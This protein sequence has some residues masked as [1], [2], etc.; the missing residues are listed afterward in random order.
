MSEAADHRSDEISARLHAVASSCPDPA[1]ATTAFLKAAFEA[2]YD[3]WDQRVLKHA[4]DIGEARRAG[5]SR[6]QR[7]RDEYERSLIEVDTRVTQEYTRYG[8]KIGAS[9]PS[10]AL[11]AP[12][13]AGG[14]S[15]A[16]LN[17]ALVRSQQ[18]PTM[19]PGRAGIWELQTL[20]ALA[21][22][23]IGLGL[24]AALGGITRSADGGFTVKYALFMI[25]PLLAAP[26][27]YLW[28]QRRAARALYLHLCRLAVALKA[29]IEVE[30]EHGRE[31]RRRESDE[32][33]EIVQRA[34][35]A[36]RARALEG[37][38][39]LRSA[40][41]DYYAGRAYESHGSI[42]AVDLG[43][44]QP[45]A[46]SASAIRAGMFAVKADQQS[47]LMGEADAASM[48]GGA[49][50]P[51]NSEHRLAIAI[52]GG[53]FARFCRR[54][55]EFTNFG[56]EREDERK[57]VGETRAGL[58]EEI[59]SDLRSLVTERPD[60]G[61]A[62]EVDE[63]SQGREK[64]Q[65]V[66]DS[67]SEPI[68]KAITLQALLI[69]ADPATGRHQPELLL[70]TLGR[71]VSIKCADAAEAEA[72]KARLLQ[73]LQRDGKHADFVR[74]AVSSATDGVVPE[75]IIDSTGVLPAYDLDEVRFARA[76]L[77][78]EK[79]AL[80][81]G[82]LSLRP[83]RPLL[84]S[85]ANE[86][87]MA[88]AREATTAIVWRLL[89]NIPPGRVHFTFI[90]PVGL[91]QNVAGFLELADSDPRLVSTRAW[92]DMRHIEGRLADL[93]THMETV[94]QKYL[95]TIHK[96]IDAYNAE[97][98]AIEAYRVLVVFDFPEQFSEEAFH[99]LRRIIENGS[100]C[101]VWPLIVARADRDD[102][103]TRE[104][105]RLAPLCL[106]IAADGAAGFG[107]W[108]EPILDR[109]MFVLDAAPPATQI[110]AAMKKIGE[111]AKEGMRVEVPFDQV[112]QMAAIQG[113]YSA[114]DMWTRS[115]LGGLH[116]PLGPEGAHKVRF[117]DFGS[118]TS[119]HALVVGRPGSG[120]SNL[121][122]VIVTSIARLY[123]PD[124]VKL[125]LIDFKK[126]VEFKAYADAALAHAEVIA[127]ES[128]RE[129]GVSV[130]R[131]LDDELK[132][133]GELYRREGVQNISAYRERTSQA[134]PRIL[135]VVD[136][137]QEMFVEDDQIGRESALLLD[138]IVRQGRAFGM[139]VLLG[140][141]TLSNSEAF[142]RGTRDQITVRIALQCSEA[143]SRLIL[144]DDNTAAR[145]LSRPGE[146]IY[147]A[148]TGLD[149]DNNFF[150]VALFSDSDREKHLAAVAAKAALAKV[151]SRPVVFEGHESAVLERSAPLQ[152]EIER[153]A[154]PEAKAPV[155]WLGEP[156]ALKQATSMQLR[157]QGGANFLVLTRIEEEGLGV[158]A[159]AIVSIASQQSPT[160]AR[161]VV[162]NLLAAE[163]AWADLPDRLKASLPHDIEIV[164]RRGIAAALATLG[165]AL[166]ERLDEKCDTTQSC[167]LVILG[168]HRA[169]EL[170]IDD[171]GRSF[172]SEDDTKPPSEL[173]AQFLRDG[174]DVGFHTL[175]WC[176]SY[177]GLERIADRGSM[178]EFG[179][180]CVGAL[181]GRESQA[182]LDSEAAV[183]LGERPHRMIM[184]DDN[185][186]GVLETFR[187]YA[188][189]AADWIEATGRA[190]RARKP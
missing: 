169:R 152:A 107:V 115:S 19:H 127:I 103:L 145:L 27:F 174:P 24:Y 146:A 101:G 35:E 5:Q 44:W 180:R 67:V 157:R 163:T 15:A 78:P 117:L 183:K 16:D 175:V 57:P 155:A 121:M 73:S 96:D 63:T 69:A 91:G 92:T 60:G 58:V 95:R 68:P 80:I 25:V 62:I 139:H 74:F 66:L 151:T 75:I 100:R 87:A 179:I 1:Q 29:R 170:R 147:N 108:K 84:L 59:R 30:F 133:R 23:A 93:S 43:Q 185:A 79:L 20:W 48:P 137:F 165:T 114:T 90:D 130:L 88:A 72:L 53:T 111:R 150:Q 61:V 106:N 171:S 132:R 181:E 4:A 51:E 104:L 65:W 162:I 112:L 124:E 138:R 154:W 148:A 177:A 76:R 149:G 184:A 122:H 2:I 131:G 7:A 34:Y 173:F 39:A 113:G 166:Q 46:E 120:K 89:A 128:E 13:Y 22:I 160:Q 55:N 12:S 54:R 8:Q 159:S 125:Y 182:M 17:T 11:G 140:S 110:Q 172:L 129:F 26:P 83:W 45:P 14:V 161:F 143:D 31:A 36:D 134:M 71:G 70:M 187:P 135:L 190:L 28:G 144:S 77:D 118:G 42:E 6:L 49:S 37:H 136:E 167:Y 86:E 38:A 142:S 98:A 156:I 33:V 116:V 189:P 188:I 178:G 64:L 164:P 85:A 168:L 41:A 176:E 123:S 52:D 40:V 82:M 102:D 186:I 158:V 21:L 10:S 18:T 141:Q 99:H 56:V 119:H 97:A 9:F 109:P 3:P 94:I 50:G 126:G 47:R 105:R 81:P 32:L 153:Q